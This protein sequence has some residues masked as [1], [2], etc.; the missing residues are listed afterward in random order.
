MGYLGTKPSVAT[1]LVDGIVTADKIAAGAVTDPKI[2]AMAASKLSGVIPDANA[3]SGSVIQVVQA[4]TTSM[5]T[6]TAANTNTDTAL[7]GSITPTSASNRVLVLVTLPFI[8]N[9]G[10]AAY[11]GF[12][13]KRN[14]TIIYTPPND[15]SG[16]FTYGIGAS[17]Q[18]DGAFNLQFLDS[19]ASSSAVSYTVFVNVYP[20]AQIR[21]PYN[22]GGAT[23]TTAV[24]T[25]ME[26]AA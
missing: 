4:T 17:A 13:L 15:G 24:I 11:A 6:V 2:A 18:L 9:S 1:S 8:I 10:G 7:T 23:A 19:P 21:T 25:L 16:S 26:I 12:G 5:T 20:P 22:A 14:S 3:P